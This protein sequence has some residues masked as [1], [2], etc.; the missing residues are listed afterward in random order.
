MPKVTFNPR[1]KKVDVRQGETILR[2]ASRGRVVI[3]QRCG[4]KGQCTMCKVF[5]TDASCVSAP[6]EVEKRLI[7]EE[8]LSCGMRL[9]CQTMIQG[10]VSVEIPESPLKAIVRAQL[11][12]KK[13]ED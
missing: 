3:S 9:A 12:K 4:G 13:Q 7:S 5:V 11:L 8:H 6:Q 10:N 1:D 2:A